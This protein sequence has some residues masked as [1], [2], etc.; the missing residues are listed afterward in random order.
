MSWMDDESLKS[1]SGGGSYIDPRTGRKYAF[2][3]YSYRGKRKGLWGGRRKHTGRDIIDITDEDDAFEQFKDSSSGS[4]YRGKFGTGAYRGPGKAL[5][6]GSRYR[7]GGLAAVFSGRGGG[8]SGMT[9]QQQQFEDYLKN[10]ANWWD[11]ERL[12]GQR[13][14]ERKAMLEAQKE[15]LEIMRAE[16]AEGRGWGR[17]Q[18]AK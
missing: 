13:G 6:Q 16:A 5:S 3:N 12:S 17:T 1:S 9:P 4:F 2:M 15:G 11:T 8:R 14:Q 10:T 18:A 7:G